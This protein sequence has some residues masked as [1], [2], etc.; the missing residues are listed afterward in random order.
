M[1]RALL[2]ITDMVAGH[3]VEGVTIPTTGLAPP[4][5][6][7]YMDA[8]LLPTFSE[9]REN[10]VF[11]FAWNRGI[12]NTPHGMRYLASG[13][14]RAKASPMGNKLNW[15]FDEIAPI[16]TI[17]DACKASHPDGKVAAFGSDAWMQTGWWK[18]RDCT[19]GWGSYYSDFLTSQYAMNWMLNNP[20]WQMVLLY[21][22]Q[23]DVTGN[24]PVYKEGAAYMED[25]HHSIQQLDR[26][27][28]VV[29]TFLEEK[30]WWDETVLCIASDHGCHV[31]CNVAVANGRKKGVPEA[32]LPGY[33]DNHGAPH[34]C[35]VW[36]FEKNT[37]SDT[38]C[39]DCRRTLFML[40]GGALEEAQRG[41]EMA[42]AEII[43]F[44]PTVAKLMEVELETDGKSVL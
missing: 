32:E 38:R 21:L 19:M 29:K 43:D 22:A 7:D 10:G 41:K 17:L 37:V 26:Y 6:H 20:D 39:D 42:E 44:A 12:C 18:A 15:K 30:G 13:S 33:C 24:C 40:G 9:V 34:D 36:D 35:F 28:W 2:F 14:Y 8:G 4:N 25:K 31:G 16:P 5:V 11:A 23:Y 1:K 3:W 27:L